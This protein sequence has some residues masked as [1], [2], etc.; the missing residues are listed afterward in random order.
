M[1]TAGPKSISLVNTLEQL[2]SYL[3]TLI[4][5]RMKS[6]CIVNRFARE[7][8]Y[9]TLKTTYVLKLQ[10]VTPRAHVCRKFLTPLVPGPLSGETRDQHLRCCQTHYPLP[11]LCTRLSSF[12]SILTY[13]VNT[14]NASK[15][16]VPVPRPACWGRTCNYFTQLTSVKG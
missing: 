13:Q 6:P 7:H 2:S 15:C 11:V 5:I 12:H 16:P 14:P 3:N 9:Q 10:H 1:K 4:H 8:D